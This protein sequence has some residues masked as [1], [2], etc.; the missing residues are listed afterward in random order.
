MFPRSVNALW[1][2]LDAL[3]VDGILLL[4]RDKRLVFNP[5]TDHGATLA[6]R[7]KN[8]RACKIVANDKVRFFDSCDIIQVSLSLSLTLS[9][10]LSFGR[11]LHFLLRSFRGSPRALLK[12]SLNKQTVA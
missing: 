8:K 7:R 12:L 10:S 2:L 4:S 9:L 1:M 3:S 11:S 6:C 5:S